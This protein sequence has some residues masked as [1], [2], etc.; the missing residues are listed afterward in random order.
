MDLQI[1]RIAKSMN[2][3]TLLRRLDIHCL[4]T[5]EQLK[6]IA[7]SVAS[8]NENL[9][10]ICFGRGL[11]PCDPMRPSSSSTK[12]HIK[13]EEEGNITEIQIT[14]VSVKDICP[15]SIDVTYIEGRNNDTF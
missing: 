5:N 9:E 13:R 12:A 8:G 7:F 4:L 3:I 11:R 10:L 2:S 1:T 14:H 6:P 15:T